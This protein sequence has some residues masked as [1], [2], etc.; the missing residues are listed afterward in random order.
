[1]TFRWFEA[2]PFLFS[3]ALKIFSNVFTE[4]IRNTLTRDIPADYSLKPK[5][6]ETIA[7][8]AIDANKRVTYIVAVFVSILSAT[9]IS[10]KN[11]AYGYAALTVFIFGLVGVIGI[12][13]LNAQQLGWLETYIAVLRREVRRAWLVTWVLIIMDVILLLVSILSSIPAFKF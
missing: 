3:I 2:L 1:M 7:Y 10:Y 9:V 12:V 13:K 5:Q 6:K 8:M 4:F 11:Q